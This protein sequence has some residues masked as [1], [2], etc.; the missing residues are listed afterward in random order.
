MP[1]TNESAAL[2]KI[3]SGADQGKGWQLDPHASYLLGRSRKCSIR[4]DEA[5][6]SGRHARMEC[7]GG[8]WT[9]EDLESSHGT[10]VNRQRI[11]AKKHLFDRDR[12]QLGRVLLELRE[13]E[14]LDPGALAEIDR[15]IVMS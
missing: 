3:L 5:T 4:L 1:Q 10:R 15:G 12:I 6:V 7:Q 8:I 9:I 13:Y 11:L 14:D 2:L